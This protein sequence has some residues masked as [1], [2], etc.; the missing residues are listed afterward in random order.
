MNVSFDLDRFYRTLAHDA[1]DAVIYADA[2][3]LI[4]FWNSA[5]ARVFGFSEPEALGQSLDIIIPPNLRAR[6]WTG[7]A[8]ALRTGRTRYGAGELLAVPAL[9][10]DGA[11]ISVEFTILPI[12][13]DNGDVLGMVAI[14]RDVTKRFGELR[15]LRKRLVQLDTRMTAVHAM[16]DVRCPFG[17]TIE[18][19]ESFHTANPEH[20]VGPFGWARAG[21]S[22]EA[23]QVRDVSDPARVH[24]AFSFTWHGRGWFLLPAVHGLI[25][26]RPNSLLTRLT[27]D[28][29]YVP[30]L[31]IAGRAFDAALGRWIARFAI[32]R[33]VDDLVSF[34]ERDY[35]RLRG[36]A[37]V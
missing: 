17:L 24:K 23:S 30:P 31:G 11:C 19:V 13:D 5:A 20:R 15:A 25:T 21:L 32:E 4:R 3:G 2:N 1:P 35:E 16:R 10:R 33:F 36:E 37:Q 8:E 29:Q 26:V 6:H 14:L 12:R 9:R 22:C 18:L 27:L 7:Y 28:G 34:I